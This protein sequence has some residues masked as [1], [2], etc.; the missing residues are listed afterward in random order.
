MSAMTRVSVCKGLL[1]NHQMRFE[2]ETFK[3]SDSLLYQNVN[4]P[5]CIQLCVTYA[6]ECHKLTSMWTDVDIKNS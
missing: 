4:R 5:P 6:K 2:A 3:M 1:R